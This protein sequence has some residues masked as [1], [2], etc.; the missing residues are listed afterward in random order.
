MSASAS[1]CALPCDLS[2]GR[3]GLLTQES[4][5]GALTV[6]TWPRGCL[7]AG[8]HASVIR[9]MPLT[10]DECTMRQGSLLPQGL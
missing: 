5:C 2:I 4:A 9:P 6:L 1:N 8:M 3:H 7:H 10:L